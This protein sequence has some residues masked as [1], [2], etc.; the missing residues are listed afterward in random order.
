VTDAPRR[1]WD[2]VGAEWAQTRRQWLWRRH[3]DAVNARLL[4]R[5][6]PAAGSARL[7]KTDAFD[8]A[9]GEG[10]L[11]LLAAHARS[12]VEVDLAGSAVR[13]LRER[14]PGTLG[15]VADVRALPF[16]SGSFDDVVSLSTLD[17]FASPD[18]I[19]ASLAELRRV[20]RRDGQLVL[21]LD[22][23]LNPI[24]ALRNALP[25][26]WLRRTGLVPYQ[27]GVTLSPRNLH[28][29]L[30]EA[31]FRVVASGAIL[32]A[33]RVLAVAISW[34]FARW[35]ANR[36]AD[37]LLRFLMAC[38]VLERLPTRRLTAYFIAVRARASG[39]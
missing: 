29:A 11:P 18:E 4:Q 21:T 24:V 12:V 1:Y 37:L 14:Y 22:N 7:L 38:E 36:A 28:H 33:P 19:A 5:W 16:A 35:G 39:T 34:L 23:P 8:E 27:V 10:V 15:V 9:V 13:R 6:T 25:Y 2:E 17:H 32:H 20:L 26:R 3:S 31:G 30:H